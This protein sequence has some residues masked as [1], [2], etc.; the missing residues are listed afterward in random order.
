[1]V[2][3][4]VLISVVSITSYYRIAEPGMVQATSS[5]RWAPVLIH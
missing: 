1:M 3:V 2:R 4:L 5:L